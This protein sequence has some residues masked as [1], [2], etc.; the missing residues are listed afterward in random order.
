[1]ALSELGIWSPDSADLYKLVQNLA[2]MAD[3]TDAAIQS[4][5]N[6]VRVTSA[7]RIVLDPVDLTPGRLYIETDTHRIW[8]WFGSW[9]CVYARIRGRVDRSNVPS[10]FNSSVWTNAAGNFNWTPVTSVGISAYNNGWAAPI[11]GRYLVTYDMRA[12]G[13]FLAGFS[14][15]YVGTT[16]YV[17]GAQSAP[18]IQN[19]AAASAALPVKLNAG[20][21]VRPYILAGSGTIDLL[22]SAGRFAIE[23]VGND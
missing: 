4:T 21:T 2:T 13:A 6:A 14:V 5:W 23:W 22:P 10:T 11:A 9:V 12:S 1:M 19:V 18:A 3:T 8:A 16:P 20:D 17:E 7:Q 15:N